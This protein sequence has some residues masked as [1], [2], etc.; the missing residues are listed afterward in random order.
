MKRNLIHILFGLILSI[1]ILD[2]EAKPVEDTLG[3]SPED[4][5]VLLAGVL[6]NSALRPN[7]DGTV[8]DPAFGLI[9]QKC[10]VGQVYR[11]TQNDCQG[12]TAGSVLNPLDPNRYG[13]RELPFCDTKTHAC[14]QVTPLPQVLIPSSQIV[15][16][17]VSEAFQA[18]AILGTGWRVPGLPELKRMSEV[19]RFALLSN[20]PQTPEGDY[21]SSWS[22]E[23]DLP[24]ETA[25][26]VSFD[27]QS[28]GVEKRIPKTERNYVRCVRNN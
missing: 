4:T 17:G 25:Y 7:S 8:L 16:A 19:G 28:F 2:C 9:W 13:A 15:I 26:A 21:W 24:G 6:T 1:I 20:F 11:P 5:N 12:A 18:C 23:Q 14:N 22:N 3:F 10:S 27:R